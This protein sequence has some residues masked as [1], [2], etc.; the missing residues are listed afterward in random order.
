MFRLFRRGKKDKKDKKVTEDTSE[1]KGDDSVQSPLDTP[2]ENQSE[3]I[4]G[5]TQVDKITA[6]SKAIT[7]TIPEVLPDKPEES[8]V[9]FWPPIKPIVESETS[10]HSFISP[11]IFTQEKK[12]ID[13]SVVSYKPI[14]LIPITLEERIEGALFSVGRPIHVSELIENLQEESPHVKRTIRKLSK[15]RSKTSPILINEI[16]KDRW[17]LQLNPIY[18]DFF[19][20]LMPERFMTLEERRILTEIA[21][22]QPISLGM[23]KKIV[24]QIGPLKINEICTNLEKNGYIIGESRARS[25]VY[26]STPKFA[27]DF[28]FDDESRRLKL[29]MLW[30]LK[31]LMGDYEEEEEEE[32]ETEEELKEE[33]EEEETE[34]EL[35]EEEEEEEVEEK[36]IEEEE[37]E[38]Q[39]DKSELDESEELQLEELQSEESQIKEPQINE[40]RLEEE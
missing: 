13:S 6:F 35:K 37:V 14:E 40:L 23:I 27:N 28:G 15:N 22:R 18:Y 16:S 12:G 11:E 17:V 31:R 26:T 10:I 3:T 4:T 7:E 25:I 24:K 5:M 29:Q 33:E 38:I 34:E 8:I 20:S 32:E 39:L 30:R 21:Y 19:Y 1:I 2:T 9:D 36:E